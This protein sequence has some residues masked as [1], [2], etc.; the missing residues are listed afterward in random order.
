[1]LVGAALALLLI[2]YLCDFSYWKG[3]CGSLLRRLG[4]A[5]VLVCLAGGG[6]LSIDD[7]PYLPLAIAVL[8]LPFAAYFLRTTLYAANDSSDVSSTGHADHPQSTRE[9]HAKHA[10]VLPSTRVWMRRVCRR[11]ATR[12][13]VCVCVSQVSCVMGIN[14]VTASLIVMII[15]T[16]WLFGAWTTVDN[17]WFERRQI[18]VSA[19]QCHHRE[20]ANS[21]RGTASDG[22]EICLAAF[23][24]WASPLMLAAN[25]R[26]LCS[27]L[28]CQHAHP[29]AGG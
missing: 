16:C 28:I 8:F 13:R 7:F 29:A 15:W 17:H 27:P 19:A 18:F 23:L 11:D 6:L 20:W 22:S 12:A 3:H 10:G 14:F 4:T 2:L 24:L 21:T 9:A 5:V 25:V 26:R 1:M